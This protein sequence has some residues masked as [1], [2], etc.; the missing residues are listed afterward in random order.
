[1]EAGT[2]VVGAKTFV[3]L[4][5]Q[6]SKAKK[7]WKVKQADMEAEIRALRAELEELRHDH[8]QVTLCLNLAERQILIF[9]Y[10]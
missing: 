8:S 3:S 6:F 5:E 1:M 2:D 4:Q 9:C 7:V 10:G